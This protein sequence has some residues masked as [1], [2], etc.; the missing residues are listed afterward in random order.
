[1]VFYNGTIRIIYFYMCYN[2]IN[3]CTKSRTQVSKTTAFIHT[4]GTNILYLWLHGLKMYEYLLCFFW[5][6]YHSKVSRLGSCTFGC[7]DLSHA[8]AETKYNYYLPRVVRE[9]LQRHY[10]RLC[11]KVNF[12]YK[13]VGHQSASLTWSSA[14][15]ITTIAYHPQ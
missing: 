6:F 5:F 14:I 12:G 8:A 1:M 13:N 3:C 9:P 11:G 4:Y 15:F 7:F 10:R 2:V